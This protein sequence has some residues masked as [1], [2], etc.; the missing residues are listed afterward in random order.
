MNIKA[1]K[2]GPESPILCAIIQ[3]PDHGCYVTGQDC[4]L[5]HLGLDLPIDRICRCNCAQW[6]FRDLTSSVMDDA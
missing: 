2:T 5:K 3:L 4:A 6:L 1:Q